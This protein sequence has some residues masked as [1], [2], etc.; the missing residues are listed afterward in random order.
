MRNGELA[1]LCSKVYRPEGIHGLPASHNI[2]DAGVWCSILPACA[3]RPFICVFRGTVDPMGWLYDFD[4]RWKAHP[5]GKVH[6]GFLYAWGLLRERV[7]AI[8]GNEP[9]IL[10]GHSLG[11]GIATVAAS[12]VNLHGLVTFGCPRVGNQ[13]FADK[14][15]ALCAPIV[16]GDAPFVDHARYVN[17]FDPFPWV[18]G[19]LRG[20]RHFSQARWFNGEAFQDGYDLS[21]VLKMGLY[22]AAN[23]FAAGWNWR[24]LLRGFMGGL[25]DYHDIE[26]YVEALQCVG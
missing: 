22:C 4:I 2:A 13:A 5:W 7:L 18:P 1:Q 24:S 11:G 6:S 14:L 12:E 16:V 9:V 19:F 25:R 3:V 26:N 20:S 15:A 8:V 23:L 10:T 17:A 21:H